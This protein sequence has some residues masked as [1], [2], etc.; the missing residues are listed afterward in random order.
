MTKKNKRTGIKYWSTTWL[1]LKQDFPTE[2]TNRS[3]VTTGRSS[4]SLTHRW[5]FTPS[6]LLRKSGLVWLAYSTKPSIS[7]RGGL[8]CTREKESA[9]K[10]I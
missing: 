10:D 9:K 4:L 1:G 8:Y 3:S 5:N 7:Q 2:L 6:V